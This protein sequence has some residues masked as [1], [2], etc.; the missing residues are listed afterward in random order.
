MKSIVKAT[1]RVAVTDYVEDDLH[2][3]EEQLRGVGVDLSYAQLK[4]ASPDELLSHVADADVII[5]NM[6]QL[7]RDVIQGLRQCRLIIRHGVGYDNVDIAA[8]TEQQ[9]TVAHIPDYCIEEVAE[10]TVTLILGCQRQLLRQHDAL[11]RSA[12][13]GS[14]DFSGLA[15]VRRL[16]GKTVGILGL[17]RIGGMVYRML[18]GFGVRRVVCDPYLTA[19]RQR[20]YGVAPVPLSTLLE[21]SD[22]VTLH[23]PLSAET[24]HLIDEPQLRAMKRTACLINTARGGLVNLTALDRALREG[25][26]AHAGVDVY[27]ER[28]PPERGMLLLNNDRATCTPH[29]SWLSVEAAWSI[30]EKIVDEV[31]RFVEGK[32]PLHVVEA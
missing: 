13:S 29:A 8:A 7:T 21:Q 19:A 24:Y 1:I 3:E 27:E 5:V 10:Q 22:I 9:I 18:D 6:A 25:W 26:I 28:E 17:G 12:A 15:G 16:R 11:L 30:R 14:W 31:L 2:W 32:A 23:T 4:F 20:E